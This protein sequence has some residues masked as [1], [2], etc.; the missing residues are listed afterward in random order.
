MFKQ[1]KLCQR[2]ESNIFHVKLPTLNSEEWA[3]KLSLQ[4]YEATLWRA[5]DIH[6]DELNA[7]LYKDYIFG[8]L[9]LKRMNDEYR[10]EWTTLT[11]E[12]TQQGL[13]QEEIFERLKD[14]DFYHSF[15]V[16]DRAWSC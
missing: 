9:F 11:H 6:R 8:L 7:A 14:S 15:F 12:Y 16:L 5:A 13:P 4:E 10:T 1:H 3:Q 2:W